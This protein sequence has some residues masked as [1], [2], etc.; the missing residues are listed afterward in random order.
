MALLISS[1]LPEETESV[2]TRV[3]GCALTVHR[4]L[5]PGFLEGIY[6]TALSIE[7]SVNGIAFERE[8]AIVVNYRGIAIPGQRVDFVVAD[9]VIVEIKSVARL[10]PIFQAK[11]ISY[12][13][14]TGLRVGLLINFNSMLLKEGLKRIVVCSSGTCCAQLPPAQLSRRI[15]VPDRSVTH[16]KQGANRRSRRPPSA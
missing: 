9:S 6:A 8:R 13:R 7:L 2:V 10:D 4:V 5:G 11:L 14:T 1:T 16:G 15:L 12:L 3:I